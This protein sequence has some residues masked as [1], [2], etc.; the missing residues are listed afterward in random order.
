MM[1]S[2]TREALGSF[3][4]RSV[5][6]GKGPNEMPENYAL[7]TRRY[8]ALPTERMQSLVPGIR[9]AHSEKARGPTY[10]YRW[11]DLTIVVSSMPAAA[12]AQHLQGAA[13]YVRHIYHG[14]VP[15]RGER[16]IRALGATTMVVGVEI[17]PSTDKEGRTE[18]LVGRLCGGLRP[19]IFHADAFFDWMSRLLLAPDGRF[20]PT[21]ECD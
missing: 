18:E 1:A 2:G 7:Y 5:H 6:G 11:Q 10:T 12:M 17:D 8:D 4:T 14:K 21:A 9:P 16:L 20:D 19:I 15:E 3:E 13:G